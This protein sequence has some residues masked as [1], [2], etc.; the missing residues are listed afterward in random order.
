MSGGER[1]F[2]AQIS[3]RDQRIMDAWDSGQSIQVIAHR[4]S[5]PVARVSAVVFAFAEGNDA[6]TSEQDAMR[7]SAM[8]RDA[9]HRLQGRAA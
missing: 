9:I 4:L 3:P 7:G 6:R 1:L 8:L 5:I 2:P